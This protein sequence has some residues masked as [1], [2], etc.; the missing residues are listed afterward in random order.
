MTV[1]VKHVTFDGSAYA[2]MPQVHRDH[3]RVIT[4]RVLREQTASGPDGY[5]VDGE[6]ECT[7]CIEVIA[8]GLPLGNHYHTE[9]E[10]FKG[11]GKGN[12]YLVPNEGKGDLTILE[13]PAD[14]WEVTVPAGTAHTFVFDGESDDNGVIAVLV[15]VKGW[16]FEKGVNTFDAA[17]YAAPKAA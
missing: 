1:E 6:I 9:D 8:A 11:R 15:S 4:E 17:I 10:P 16:E 7:T 3:R 14:G 2:G 12:L 13:L 5:A